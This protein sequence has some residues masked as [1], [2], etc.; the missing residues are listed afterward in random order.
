MRRI[1]TPPPSAK[2][3]RASISTR[4][5]ASSSLPRSSPPGWRLSW[6]PWT[7]WKRSARPTSA[8]GSC[9][10]SG[11]ATPC[12][13][14]SGSM[15]RGIPRTPLWHRRS[16][17]AG[18]RP[19][20]RSTSSS[21]PIPLARGRRQA[22]LTLLWSGGVTTTHTVTCPP[23]G[24]HGT[25]DEDVLAQIRVLAQQL[26]D[27]QIA[28]TLNAAG[29]CTLTG[30]P[31]TAV[32][33]ASMR[34]QHAIPTACP[35]DPTAGA[36]RG[37]GL[38]PVRVAAQQLGVSPS[39]VHVWVQ[40]GVL[41][42]DQSQPRSYRWVQLTEADLA[43]VT[44]ANIAPCPILPGARELMPQSH[45][46]YAA[47]GGAVRAGRYIAYRH[48]VGRHWEWRFHARVA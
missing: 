32:R 37:D 43:R 17:P 30:K 48:H 47:G 7:G 36:C 34:T 42:G 18:G 8:S 26:P 31:W 38:V 3:S 15:M 4:R 1:R 9:A 33:V 11:R 20:A 16:K 5:C 39:L 27:H 19:C 21:A 22:A 13:W 12:T 45:C 40:H 23:R 44:R 6:R 25:T 24:W 41:V 29:S 46:T 10:W 2:R 14:P 28:Q 35:V